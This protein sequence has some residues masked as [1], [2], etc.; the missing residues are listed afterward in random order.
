MVL[1]S[2]YVPGN[3]QTQCANVSSVPPPS[4]RRLLHRPHR[5]SSMSGL[6]T[7][8]N[9][10]LT[11]ERWQGH[12]TAW[13]TCICTQKSYVS[14]GESS[15]LLQCFNP[16]Q[17]AK[18]LLSDLGRRNILLPTKISMASCTWRSR[19]ESCLVLALSLQKSMEKNRHLSLLHT[20]TA[21]LHHRLWLGWIV[22]TSNISSTCAW[23]SFTIGR[24]ILQNL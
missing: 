8:G 7:L 5:L 9:S 6:V 10:A 20:R 1:A 4:L 15:V 22:P 3:D 13:T 24:E 17:F 2:G 16:W 18:S 11:S 14:C 21:A 23:T 19:Y 12:C